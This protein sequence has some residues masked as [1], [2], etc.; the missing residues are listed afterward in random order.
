MN[1]SA[2][3]REL[4]SRIGNDLD[5]EEQKK[6]L[7]DAMARY[8]GLDKLESSKDIEAR[9]RAEGPREAFSTGIKSLDDHLKG[10]FRGGQMV[11]VAAITKHGKTE[12][13]IHLTKLMQNMVPLWFS[14]EDG[15]EELVERFIDAGTEVPMFYTPSELKKKDAKWIEERIVESIV[16]YNT[17]LV[18][19]D[20]INFMVPRTNN[21]AH[22]ISFLTKELKDMATRWNITIVLVAQLTKSQLDRQPDLNDI[23]ESSAIA[24]DASTVILIWR[25]TVRSNN[26]INITNNINVSIQ[27]ARRG[28]PGN[29]K[30]T[31]NNGDYYECDWNE[32]VDKFDNDKF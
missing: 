15:A 9:I 5:S 22:E 18:F 23:K 8:E 26:Q 32:M 30:M 6:R 14:Y 24:Q 10:G 28:K 19:V 3:L 31:Y 29:F 1:S 20:N 25:Q 4:E 11:V 21:V 2:M 7:K 12:F 16:K 17:K 13:C 27:A